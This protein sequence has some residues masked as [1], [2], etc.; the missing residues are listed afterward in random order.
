MFGQKVTKKPLKKRSFL[1]IF[2]YY[3]GFWF[4]L[5]PV[6]LV[7]PNV[8]PGPMSV[9]SLEPLPGPSV[10]FVGFASQAHASLERLPGHRHGAGDTALRFVGRDD[11][12]APYYPPAL[13]APAFFHRAPHHRPSPQKITAGPTQK[14][15]PTACIYD[16][17]LGSCAK[18]RSI[19]SSVGTK[20]T[21][22]PLWNFS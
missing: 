16:Q 21:I 11:P 10:F 14:A 1:R 12:G 20:F 22:S 4:A 17:T 9:E 15:G 13:S 2:L 7:F 18:D 6:C 8:F 3:G 5:R 19:S